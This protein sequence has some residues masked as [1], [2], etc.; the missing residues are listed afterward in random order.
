MAVF[1][2]EEKRK[3]SETLSCPFFEF[4]VFL[5]L[6][7]SN[8]VAVVVFLICLFV[9]LKITGLYCSLNQMTSSTSFYIIW[10]VFSSS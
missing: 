1:M 2:S 3:N 9:Q 6:H 8:A 4:V 10:Y 5:L 7:S